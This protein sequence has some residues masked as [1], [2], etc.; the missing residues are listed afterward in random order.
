[1]QGLVIT[2]KGQE[3]ISKLI[4]GTAR[5]TFTKIAASDYDYSAAALEELES[6]SE[7]KQ[8]AL[9]SSVTV[10]DTSLVKVLAR[11]DNSSLTEGYYVK[12][13]GLYAKDSSTSEEILYGV[14][15]ADEVADYM[16]VFGGKT[17]TGITYRL[18]VKVDNSDSVSLVIDPAAVP[19]MEQV[20]KLGER[21]TITEKDI[22]T[23]EN[24]L[25]KDDISKMNGGTV[26][27]NIKEFYAFMKHIQDGA[28]AHNRIYVN[29][30][31]TDMWNDGIFSKNV[32]NGTFKDIFPGMYITKKYS[33]SF[34]SN[35]TEDFVV[36]E[37]DYHLHHGDTETTEHH[38]LMVMKN[39]SPTIHQMN[40]SNTTANGYVG[41]AMWTSV[42]PAFATGMQNAFG[43]D[44]I[45]SHRELLTTSMG[46]N[47][48]S[49]AGAGLTGASN[50]SAWQDVLFNL[51]NNAMLFGVTSTSS[52]FFDTGDCTKQIALF[53]LANELKIAH[54]G[55][56]GG[57]YW[58]WLR[59]V[60]SSTTFAHCNSSGDSTYTD[61]SLSSVVRGYFLLR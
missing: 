24:L 52:S 30:D 3:L 32:Q 29:E 57:R 26:T 21:I 53:E 37:L 31:I 54:Q 22:T 13:V 45:L 44:H 38:A 5:V 15:L 8:E 35:V 7:I 20:E 27:G 19:T 12:I 10:T 59:D 41:S 48:A 4:A 33:T 40:T 25:G 58:N 61:A 43:K 56:G 17:V 49:M 6:L 16:P 28:A 50:N 2:N 18:N 51:M 14:S 47:L 11:I 39:A 36:G 46:T 9:V 1:M 60:V 42:I 55:K 23:I 34:Q